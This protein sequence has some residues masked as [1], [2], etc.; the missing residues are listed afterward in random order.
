VLVSRHLASWSSVW[1]GGGADDSNEDPDDRTN[2]EGVVMGE[3]SVSSAKPR[4]QDRGW[5]RAK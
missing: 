5:S 2:D 1:F 3:D 4:E